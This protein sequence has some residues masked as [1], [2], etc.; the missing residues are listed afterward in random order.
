M[1]RVTE[2]YEARIDQE[3]KSPA[4]QQ[5][6][7]GRPPYEIGCFNDRFPDVPI[8]SPKKQFSTGF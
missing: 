1:T 7:Y 4:Q 5:N 3:E 6:Q 8:H 2:R